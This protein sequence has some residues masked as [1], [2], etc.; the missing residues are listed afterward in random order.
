VTDRAPALIQLEHEAREIADVLFY[1]IDNQTRAVVVMIEVAY[2]VAKKRNVVS[3][4]SVFKGPDQRI[5]NEP[6]SQL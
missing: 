6:I 3:V 4:V 2:F 1:V 5:C